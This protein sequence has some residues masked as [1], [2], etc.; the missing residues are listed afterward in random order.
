VAHRVSPGSCS[1]WPLSKG[2]RTTPR[3]RRRR[4]QG[5]V[6]SRRVSQ[7]FRV[8]RVAGCGIIG[9]RRTSS[10][11]LHRPWRANQLNDLLKSSEKRVK[12][13]LTTNS[14]TKM[15]DWR[16]IG[17]KLGHRQTTLLVRIVT[18]YSHKGAKPSRQPVVCAEDA[19]EQSR[20][21]SKARQ[22]VQRTRDSSSKI[23]W[24]LGKR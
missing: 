19:C 8:G 17:G 1:A 13:R 12:A 6:Q 21:K 7:L 23:A 18:A 11:H 2:N 22:Y 24:R 20:F 15:L 10:A 16:V 14:P 5:V 3:N 9:E 4:P